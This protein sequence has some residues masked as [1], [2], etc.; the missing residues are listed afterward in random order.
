MNKL[1]KDISSLFNVSPCDP[2]KYNELKIQNRYTDKD[3]MAIF[4]VIKHRK[5]TS[6]TL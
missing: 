5:I 2:Q 6:F 4:L 1:L 3:K